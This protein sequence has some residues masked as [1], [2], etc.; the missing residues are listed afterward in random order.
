MYSYAQRQAQSFHFDRFAPSMVL[1]IMGL[2]I[3]R[4]GADTMALPV[5]FR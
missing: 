1:A 5:T 2:G 3:T 4:P